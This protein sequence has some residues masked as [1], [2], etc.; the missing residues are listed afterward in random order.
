MRYTYIYTYVY[1]QSEKEV[2]KFEILGTMSLDTFGKSTDDANAGIMV[3]RYVEKE[4]YWVIEFSN[5]YAHLRK[6]GNAKK[7]SCPRYAK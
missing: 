6:R 3:N 1:T 2:K 7:K 4:A 5:F